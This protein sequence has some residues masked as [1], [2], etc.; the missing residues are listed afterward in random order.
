MHLILVDAGR[1]RLLAREDFRNS[2]KMYKM[3][4]L[5]EHLPGLS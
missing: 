3:R 1:S 5:H 4:R 2:L